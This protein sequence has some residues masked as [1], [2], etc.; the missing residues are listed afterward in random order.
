MSKVH[1]MRKQLSTTWAPSQWSG[2]NALGLVHELNDHCLEV[3]TNIAQSNS[4]CGTEIV[5]IFRDQW[6]D[7]DEN[8]R[9]R[10]AGLPVLV[11]D[12]HFRNEEF[13]RWARTHR[14]G[15]WKNITVS[16]S[17]MEHLNLK[18][19]RQFLVRPEHKGAKI[20]QI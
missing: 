5:S 7:L 12:L 6:R 19:K 13:W 16:Q 9:R 2:S 8:S 14:S 3:F 1:G 18:Q 17:L 10:A 4:T 20:I 15:D 11:L